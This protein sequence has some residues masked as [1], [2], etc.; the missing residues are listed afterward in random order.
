[1]GQNAFMMPTNVDKYISKIE[2]QEK[3]DIEEQEL[4]WQ[5]IRNTLGNEQGIQAEVENNNIITE[6]EEQR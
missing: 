1:M 3:I 4:K 6:Q 2:Q 5:E